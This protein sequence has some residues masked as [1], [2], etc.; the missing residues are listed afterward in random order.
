MAGKELRINA[1]LTPVFTPPIDI[2]VGHERKTVQLVDINVHD[3]IYSF[4]FSKLER[5]CKLCKENQISYIE[6][7]HFFNP[8]TVMPKQTTMQPLCV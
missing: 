6:I 4:D 7:P 1:L 3:G 8:E 2:A 5:W